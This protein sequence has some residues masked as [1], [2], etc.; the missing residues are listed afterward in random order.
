LRVGIDP[1]QIEDEDAEGEHQ[2][3]WKQTAPDPRK[4]NRYHKTTS[5]A[6]SIIIRL[7]IRLWPSRER[8]KTT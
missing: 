4:L 7:W 2:T 8:L 1:N 3:R 6:A 5:C